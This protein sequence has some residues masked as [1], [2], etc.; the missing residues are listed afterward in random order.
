MPLQPLFTNRIIDGGNIFTGL[1]N[2]KDLIRQKIGNFYVINDGGI[3]VTSSVNTDYNVSYGNVVKDTTSILPSYRQTITVASS[4]FYSGTS[5]EFLSTFIDGGVFTQQSFID[6]YFNFNYPTIDANSVNNFQYFDYENLTTLLSTKEI[7]NLYDDE[8]N[9]NSSKPKNFP[10][11]RSQIEN[12]SFTQAEAT[13]KTNLFFTDSTKTIS[14]ITQDFLNCF[15]ELKFY[16]PDST[17]P[18]YAFYESLFNSNKMTNK[19]FS[20]FKRTDAAPLDFYVDRENTLATVGVRSILD[21]FTNY[22]TVNFSDLADESFYKDYDE[23]S[24]FESQFLYFSALSGLRKL[25]D[26][27]TRKSF[28]SLFLDNDQAPHFII[29]YKVEKFDLNGKS[30]IQ[31]FYLMGPSAGS[32]IDTMVSFGKVYEYKFTSIVMVFGNNYRYSNLNYDSDNGIITFDLLN[33]PS[34]QFVEVP[35]FEK[36]VV[37]VEPPNPTPEIE[38]YN[39]RGEKNNLIISFKTNENVHL[40]ENNNYPIIF[41]KDFENMQKIYDQQGGAQIEFNNLYKSNIFEI[42]RIDFEKP[43]SLLQFETNLLT[44]IGEKGSLNINNIFVDKVAPGQKYY[45]LFRGLSNFGTPTNFTKIFEVE[46][47]QDSDETYVKYDT[48][49]FEYDDGFA[50]NK[51]FKKYLSIKTNFQHVATNLTELGTNDTDLITL[52]SIGVASPAIWGKTFK[53]RLISKKTGKKIDLNLT[54]NLKDENS[55]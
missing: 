28:Q 39:R 15:A 38:F 37:C 21:F 24:E 14:P 26:N 51:Q 23:A 41:Q 36:R 2:G 19:L 8:F 3:V 55:P 10:E 42:Y 32:I 34:V 6:H 27:Y 5:E 45:Y 1:D 9:L 52:N 13:K 47:I 33:Q 11:F 53:I 30:P 29:G 50:D 7:Y 12:Y 4:S 35:V 43:M 40:S 20:F 25:S 54:Y 48:F 18:V 22:D 16:T 44:S 17:D 46:L 31:T 49:E